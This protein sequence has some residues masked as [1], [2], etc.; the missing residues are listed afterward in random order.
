MLNNEDITKNK[1]IEDLYK[2]Q[3]DAATYG[4]ESFDILSRFLGTFKTKPIEVK[5]DE[6]DW[7][8]IM[9]IING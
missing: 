2:M 4:N 5:Q 3:M 6:S 8:D 7:S 9:S 1:T